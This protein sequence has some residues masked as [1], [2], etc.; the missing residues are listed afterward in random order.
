MEL[1][2]LDSARARRHFAGV[3]KVMEHAVPVDKTRMVETPEFQSRLARVQAALAAQGLP[4]G[5][6]FSDEHYC[7]DVPYL[8]GNTNITVE[9]VAGIVGR[10]GFHLLAGLEGGYV[11]Q[12]LSGRSGCKVP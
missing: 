2:S 12:Q 6:V 5:L 4:V 1:R 11:A 9:Q 3:L 10:T 7:G 8:G